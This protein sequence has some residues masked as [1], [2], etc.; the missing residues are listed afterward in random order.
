MDSSKLAFKLYF[1]P[2]TSIDVEAFVPVFH[3]WIQSRALHGH[4]LIDAADYSHVYQGPGTMLIS[5]EANL[6]IDQENSRPS[7]M[8]VRKAP[9][10][11]SLQDRIRTVL[12]YTLQAASML[13]AAPEL[14]GNLK[15]KTDEIVFRINDRLNGPN[16]QGTFDAIKSDLEAVLKR[17]S[18]GAVTLSFTPHA[19]QLFEVNAKLSS[20]PTVTEM[21]QRVS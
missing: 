6:H 21:L 15:F 8:Y 7:L 10:A 18:G 4:Q 12:G 17:A 11:G 14:T 5:H 9:I 2:G 20:A 1:R 3:H 13:E 19:E 16:T